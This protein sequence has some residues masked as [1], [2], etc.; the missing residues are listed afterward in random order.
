MERSHIDLF[1]RQSWL[2]AWDSYK[3]SLTH[4]RTRLWDYVIITAANKEQAQV[5]Q[6]HIDSRLEAGVLPKSVK[7]IVIPDPKDKRVGSGGATLNVLRYLKKVEGC[8]TLTGL[9]ILCIHSGGDS[10]RIPQCSASGKLFSPVPRMLPDGRR[11]TLF[12]EL[13]IWLTPVPPRI[14]DGML[15]CSGDALLL[16]NPLQIDFFG[17]GAAAIS[18]KQTPEVGE[19]HGVYVCDEDG[20]VKNFLHKQEKSIL[21]NNGAIDKRG[22]VDLDTGAV[23]FSG[24]MIEEL[25]SLIDTESSY[26]KYV[27][28]DVRLS[29]YA[30]FLFPLTNDATLEDYLGKE[31][32]GSFSDEL[33]ECR[34]TLWQVLSKYSLKLLR[35]APSSFIHFGTTRELLDLMVTGVSEYHWLDWSRN[36]LSNVTDKR[37]ATSNSFIE[38]SAEIGDGCY[39]EDS[40]IGTDVTIGRGCIISCCTLNNVNVP[41]GTVLHALKLDDGRFCVRKYGVSD[42]PKEKS[43]FGKPLKKPLWDAD[44][45]PVRNTMEEAVCAALSDDIHEPCLSLKESFS[46]ADTSAITAW[47]TSLYFKIRSEKLL[48]LIKQR[49]P[50]SEALKEFLL[51][52]VSK[53]VINSLLETA[54]EAEF[55]DKIRIYHYL[56]FLVSEADKD[57]MHKECFSAIGRAM[58]DASADDIF[59]NEN[60]RIN[61]DRVVINMP[62]RVNFG[63]DW[64][65]TPPHCLENGG[66]VLN[67]AFTINGSLPVEVI[68]ERCDEDVVTLA[69][70][71]EGSCQSFNQLFDLQ[72]CDDPFDSFT[73]HKAVL[74]SCGIIPQ[75]GYEDSSIMLRDILNRLGGGFKLSTHVKGIPKGSGLGTSSIL[76]GAC[77]K[78]ALDFFDTEITEQALFN[79]VLCIEQMMTT[80]GGWQDQVGGLVPGM[81]M[82]RSTPGLKQFVTYEQP[83]ISERTYKE[84]EERYCLVYTGQRRLARNLLREIVGSYLESKPDALFALVELQK[85]TELMK[86]ALE[87]DDVDSFA[88]LL[89]EHLELVKTLDSGSTNTCIDQLF[90]SIDDLL[91]GR[92]TCGAGGGGFV[93]VVL[94]KGVTKEMLRERLGEVFGDC[95]VDVWE[96]SILR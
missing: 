87:A 39:I 86:V 68:F 9:H 14:A 2:D 82:V 35:L 22:K 79:R 18:F 74:M 70:I 53:A 92:K 31:P 54:S 91:D 6:R 27:N 96:C 43:R 19:H 67:A 28:E 94:K 85:V 40:L 84:L 25:Y 21:H 10:K 55:S 11:S 83:K 5:Y 45:H 77:V 51:H 36:V 48:S 56:T 78:A 80:G 60:L 20:Y 7:F 4:P 71:D 24:S 33:T 72:C 57:D 38:P 32:E 63:G 15:V 75:S 41:D 88:R 73:I 16:F 59:Y 23:I 61:K 29:F 12:D 90:L 13:M 30:D 66:V 49:V 81:K 17:D 76:A 1:L 37:Y 46:R 47:Q 50:A 26:N 62:L 64:S 58:L 93:Q 42:N 65:D 89:N 3:Q 44:L 95:G 34:K 52:G 8:N 69:S